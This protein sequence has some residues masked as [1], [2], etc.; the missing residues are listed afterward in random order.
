MFISNE[1]LYK[2]LNAIEEDVK[3]QTG[4]TVEYIE[5]EELV[6]QIKYYHWIEVD[7]QLLKEIIEEI[8]ELEAKK[9]EMWNNYLKAEEQMEVICKAAELLRDNKVEEEIYNKF[10]RTVVIPQDKS[11]LE[12]EQQLEEIKEEIKELE[13]KAAKLNN[14][15]K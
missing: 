6:E 2:I 8:K 14:K 13:E 12:V 10:M 1:E 7:K 11:I 9:A 4:E 3:D 15:I 5:L